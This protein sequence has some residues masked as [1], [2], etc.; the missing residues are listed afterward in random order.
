VEQPYENKSSENVTKMSRNCP[1][2]PENI[3]KMSGKMN[4]LAIRNF[5]WTT[6]SGHKKNSGQILDNKTGQ[7][8]DIKNFG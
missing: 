7:I 2:Y 6:N 8:P 5:F 3:Q 4:K 1:K